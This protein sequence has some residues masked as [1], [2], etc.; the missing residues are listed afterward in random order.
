MTG[1]TDMASY[2]RMD[3][4]AQQAYNLHQN[5]PFYTRT[6]FCHIFPPSTN[7]DF[8]N[9]SDPT[10]KKV[11]LFSSIIYFLSSNAL[12]KKYSGAV[13]AI[14]NTFRTIDI[15]AELNGDKIHRL[16][17]GFTMDVALH[18]MFDNLELWF[19]HTG[20]SS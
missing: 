20:V 10:E 14:I 4:A 18:A 6:N 17:N 2:L 9:P 12:Q 5:P 3:A 19:E 8:N 7:W 16:E 1:A 11:T 13:W 15:L